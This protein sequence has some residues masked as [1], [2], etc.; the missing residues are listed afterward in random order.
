MKWSIVSLGWRFNANRMVLDYMR[1]AY[2]PAVGA[3]TARIG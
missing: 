1:N 3:T 2:L